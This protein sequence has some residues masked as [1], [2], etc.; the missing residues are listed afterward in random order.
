MKTY[1]TSLK[2]NKTI[3]FTKNYNNLRITLMILLII[4][5]IL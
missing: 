2:K 4:I 3:I 1:L 5:K